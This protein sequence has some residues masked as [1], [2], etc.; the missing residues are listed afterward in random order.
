MLLEGMVLLTLSIAGGSRLSTIANGLMVFGLQGIAFVA[1]WTEQIGTLLGNDSART[2]GTAAS[3]VMPSEAMWQLAA[4]HMQPPLL[5][6]LHLTP[7]SPA[8]VPSV[9]MVA[10][11]IG[12]VVLTLAIG[13]RSFSRRGL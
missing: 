7:F 12:Y 5:R 9:A 11:T 2:I 10:W 8:S 3:L 6:D 4:W 13:L 1:G